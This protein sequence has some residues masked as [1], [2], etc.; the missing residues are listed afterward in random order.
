MSVLTPRRDSKAVGQP[1]FDIWRRANDSGKVVN[2]LNAILQAWQ[3]ITEDWRNIES[4]WLKVVG[5]WQETLET[6]LVAQEKFLAETMK[7]AP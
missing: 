3:P 4:A 5:D 2:D 6:C 7:E 1:A